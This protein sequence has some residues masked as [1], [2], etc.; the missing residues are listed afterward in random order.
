MATNRA[1]RPHYESDR[2]GRIERVDERDVLF[3]RADL[4][5]KF[6][7]GSPERDQYYSA[8]PEAR[9]YDK[10]IADELRLGSSGGDYA[11]LCTG[12]F[13]S[14]RVVARDEFVDGEPASEK[15]V[16][17]PEEAA[18]CVKALARTLGADLVGTGPLRPEWV[19]SHVGRSFGN[20]EGFPRWGSP[21]DLSHHTDAVSMGFRMEP[22]F[23]ASAPE[24]PTVLATGVAYAIGARAAVRLA[25]YIRS[26]GYS[27]RA[28][29]VYSYGVL[30]VPVAVDCGLGELSRAGFLL[31]RKLGLGVRLGTVTTDLPLSHDGPT[32]IGVQSFCERCEICAEHCP[33]R[34]IPTGGKTEYNGVMKWTLDTESCYRYWAVVSTDCSVC[35]STCP[36]TKPS[37]WLHRALTF[38]ATF[39]GPH[40]LLMV[41]AEKLFYGHPDKRR[42]GRTH[43]LAS[44]RPTRLRLHMRVMGVVAAVL[45]AG[46]ILW[47]WLDSS[48]LDPVGWLGYLAWL[49]WTIL[50]VGAVWTFLAERTPRPAVVALVLFGA[51]SAILGVLVF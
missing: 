34:S 27:A 40:Q 47:Q 6:P 37:T 8:H 7:D 3:A 50:G 19:Y 41:A 33:S 35:M 51:V 1:R 28:H 26:L 49:A 32:D 2:V 36:W 46:G 29:H 42:R 22:D 30:P 25:Q 16:L 15:V 38:V 18:R 12:V 39:S 24:F 20:A 9:E 44:L 17:A 4:F 31:T 10:R 21:I 5:R 43:G 13:H 11:A 23:V 14:P 45:G 48:P